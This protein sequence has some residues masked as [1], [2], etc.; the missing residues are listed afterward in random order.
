MSAQKRSDGVSHCSRSHDHRPRHYW[1][2]LSA[3]WSP[4]PRLE[5]RQQP[6][7]EWTRSSCRP[8][9]LLARIWTWA[10]EDGLPADVAISTWRVVASW[11]PIGSDRLPRAV[12][13][14]LPIGAGLL[15]PRDFESVAAV[16]F[17]PLVMLAGW[18]SRKAPDR[19][20]SS[21]VPSSRWC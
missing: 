8:R 21:S 18:G 17:I 13:R 3:G 6:G 16:A 15:E 20:R 1:M 11:S 7:Q 12:H 10:S 9:T 14:Q 5:H 2:R 4:P 19:H